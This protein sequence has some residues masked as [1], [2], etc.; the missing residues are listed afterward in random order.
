MG[1]SLCRSV[2]SLDADLPELE[3]EFSVHMH[4][5]MFGQY[6]IFA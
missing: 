4:N 2:T 5:Q 6:T 3:V 1:G